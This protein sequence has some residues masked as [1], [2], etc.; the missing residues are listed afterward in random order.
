MR[1]KILRATLRAK[2][3]QDSVAMA[4]FKL[5]NSVTKASRTQTRLLMPVGKIAPM[6]SAETLWSTVMKRVMWATGTLIQS[7]IAAA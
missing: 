2:E 5:E 4:W 1:M 3:V 6:R 7:P